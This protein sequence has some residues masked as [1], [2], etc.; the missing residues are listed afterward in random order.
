MLDFDTLRK[1]FDRTQDLSGKY[2]RIIVRSGVTIL[3]HLCYGL[4]DLSYRTEFEVQ[5]YLAGDNNKIDYRQHALFSP[6]KY[7][8]VQP[9]GNRLSESFIRRDTGVSVWLEPYAAEGSGA[10]GTLFRFVKLNAAQLQSG[11]EKPKQEDRSFGENS[12]KQWISSVSDQVQPARP[13]W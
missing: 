13:G 1:A 2:G 5:D 3:E 9:S 6:E 8:Q 12:A 10:E 11:T 7:F 4:T